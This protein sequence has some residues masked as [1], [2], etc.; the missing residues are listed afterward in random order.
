MKKIS[1]V[2][3][4]CGAGASLPGAEHGP[5]YAQD[6]KLCEKLSAKGLDVQWAVDPKLY[7]Q[8]RHGQ[9]AHENLSPLGAGERLETVL[10]HLRIFADN[11]AGALR[12]GEQVVTI[13]G[14]H[15]MSAGSLAGMQ[16]AFG[17]DARLGLIWIDAHPDIHTF[18]S[19]MSKALHGMPLATVTSLDDTLALWKEF[20]IR[21]SAENIVFAG[22]RDT[23]E[24]EIENANIL[25]IT[26]PT[27]DGLRANGI[28]QT[29]QTAVK[30]LSETCD[31]IALS[32]DLDAFSDNAAPAVGSPVPGGFTPDEILPVLA[33]IV[34]NYPVPLIDIVEF[35]PTL[36][37]A[38]KTFG[39]ILRILDELLQR[40]GEPI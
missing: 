34:K 23:D 11:V 39:L 12:R 35:N 38:E 3:Y 40:N 2:P 1:L 20:A 22:L 4:V 36:P 19:S 24:G 13:G 25:G 21:L 17:P 15:T 14:D 37:G 6:N 16:A 28:A 9:Q 8:E 26:L 33:E 18:K 27:M 5:L 30:K 7:W 29:L 32:I 10:W 31:Y